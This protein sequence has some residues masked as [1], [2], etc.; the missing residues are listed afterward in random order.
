MPADAGDAVV[1]KEKIGLKFAEVGYRQP[2][3]RDTSEQG[4]EHSRL[5][6]SHRGKRNVPQINFGIEQN[7]PEQISPRTA[8]N[9]AY[10]TGHR[11]LANS[12]SLDLYGLAGGQFP[13]HHD[14]GALPAN[15]Y[16]LRLLHEISALFSGTEDANRQ[17][18]KNTFAKSVIL[19]QKRKKSMTLRSGAC[20]GFVAEMVCHRA[21]SPMTELRRTPV[22][23]LAEL[24]PLSR[25]AEYSNASWTPDYSFISSRAHD[26][27]VKEGF[28]RE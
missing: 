15:V 7:Q 16:R 3:T 1:V 24:D 25:A 23:C 4:S 14:S 9:A 26:N 27:Q 28:R 20:T 21:P 17:G 13:F 5:R 18:Q 11:L 22:L 2:A 19:V 12:N 8:W 10:D 6:V